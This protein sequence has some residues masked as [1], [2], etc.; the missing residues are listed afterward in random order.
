MTFIRTTEAL[1]AT[2]RSKSASRSAV[3]PVTYWSS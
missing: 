1:A 3:S 2:V